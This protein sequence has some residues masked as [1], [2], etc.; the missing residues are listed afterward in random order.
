[1]IVGCFEGALHFSSV[2]FNIYFMLRAFHACIVTLYS[3]VYHER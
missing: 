2:V 3:F 1:M